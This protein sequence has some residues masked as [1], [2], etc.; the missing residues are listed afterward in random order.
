MKKVLS[1]VCVSVLALSIVACTKKKAEETMPTAAPAAAPAEQAPAAA[2]A[3]QA[4]E[5]K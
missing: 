3:E 4:P 1:F 2:P 5:K